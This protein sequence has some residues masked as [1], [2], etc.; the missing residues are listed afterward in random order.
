MTTAIGSSKRENKFYKEKQLRNVITHRKTER[1][2]IENKQKF[3]FKAN[4]R[5]I[6]Q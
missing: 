2:K 1:N 6:R 3:P 4:W 5:L